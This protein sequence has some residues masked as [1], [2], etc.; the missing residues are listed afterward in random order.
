MVGMPIATIKNQSTYSNIMIPTSNRFQKIS[1]AVLLLALTLWACVS[2][3]L[4]PPPVSAVVVATYQPPP[5]PTVTPWPTP[6]PVVIQIVAQS[7]VIEPAC[8]TP[9]VD[10]WQS[11]T[12]SGSYTET[13]RMASTPM[14]CHVKRD[15][16]AYNQLVGILDPSIVFK[17][18]EAWPFD[19]ED[20]L[21]HP[22]MLNPLAR[23][24]ALVQAE[25]NGAYQLRVTDAYDSLL[26]HDPPDSEPSTRYSLHY[27]GRAIDLTTW[28]V[29]RSMYGR[30]CA[31]AHCAGFDYVK[32]EVTHCHASIN[33]NSLCTQCGE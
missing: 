10:D 19:T 2:I 28:P 21:M 8:T 26:E 5:T 14:V 7:P 20:V 12:V 29:D 25:W 13:E 24:N 15:T 22:A 31:L 11:I 16:C 18:E 4:S 23:L 9:E 27:E 1:V 30:L 33:A 17:Q 6:T 3:D 32:N